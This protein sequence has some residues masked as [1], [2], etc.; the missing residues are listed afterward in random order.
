MDQVTQSNAALVEQAAAA[1]QALE[2]QAQNL[3]RSISV[4]KLGQETPSLS[5]QGSA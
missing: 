4:F 1:A 3:V 5:Y 2:H